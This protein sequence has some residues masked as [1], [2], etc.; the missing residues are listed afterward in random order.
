MDTRKMAMELRVNHWASALHE[1]RASGLSIRQWCRENGVGEKTYYYWQRK[2]REAAIQNLKPTAINLEPG[3]QAL[4]PN[5][6]AAVSEGILEPSTESSAV[7]IEIGK[8]RVSAGKD[9]SPEQLEKTLRVLMK[10]C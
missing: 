9:T 8:F 6:W 7:T 5:G 1:R 2:L 10:L 3:G 4:V